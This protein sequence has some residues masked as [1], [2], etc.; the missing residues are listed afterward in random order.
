MSVALALRSF[1]HP[2][3]LLTTTFDFIPLSLLNVR[4][5]FRKKK[6]AKNIDTVPVKEGD[7]TGPSP[8]GAEKPTVE[9]RE[10]QDVSSN[11]FCSDY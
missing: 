8:A 2:A 5:S 7:A 4:V 3:F 11:S 1:H 10:P 9:S 6:S